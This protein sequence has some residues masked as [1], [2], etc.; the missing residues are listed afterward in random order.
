MVTKSTRT[1]TSPRRE[2]GVAR[3]L[4][5]LAAQGVSTRPAAGRGPDHESI[6]SFVPTSTI[7]LLLATS[8]LCA[9]VVPPAR[10]ARPAAREVRIVM[11][12]TV[13]IAVEGL[14]DPGPPLDAA[15]AAVARVD[16]TMSLWKDSELTR[17][18][19]EGHG[20]ASSDL[21]VVLLHALDVARASQGA[22]DPTVEPLVRAGGGLGGPQHALSASERGT[23]MARVGFSRVHVDGDTGRVTLAPGTRLDLGGIAK[24]YAA[25][26]ALAALRKAG[27]TR[28]LA[29]LGQ[30]SVGAFEQEVVVDVRDPERASAPAWARF[31]LAD[32]AVSTSGGDQ[33]PG[34]I[35]D[36]RTGLPSRKVL[37]ATVVARTGIEADA[38][39]T[40]VYVL[41]AEE[42]LRLLEQRGAAGFVLERRN[43]QRTLEATKGFVRAY[44]L[45]AAS[46]VRI[47]IRGNAP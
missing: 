41:G 38:L 20:H 28:A 16:D 31:L 45:R 30:S 17:L 23:L 21:V 24:G 8:G 14:S 6:A 7:W 25:D 42:G 22:F 2:N 1:L 3:R 43:G 4:L 35:L 9:A 10:G 18:N 39:S 15:F 27:A 5:H 11:G 40:A 44:G 26:L 47:L 33:R 29:D 19:D 36:P 12:T 37:A 46:G 32:G 34:H 13:E